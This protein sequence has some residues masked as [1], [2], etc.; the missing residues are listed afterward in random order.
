MRREAE[1]RAGGPLVI[2]YSSTISRPRSTACAPRAAASSGS[3]SPFRVADVS[4]SWTRRATNSRSGPRSEPSPCSSSRPVSWGW[5]S[6]PL[7]RW[8]VPVP[9]ELGDGGDDGG[10]TLRELIARIVHAE[11]EAFEA[12]A[13]CPA[14]GP[15]PHRSGDPG[16]RG[17]R[18][19]RPWGSRACRPGRRGVGRRR[20][21]P[22]VRGRALSGDPRRR[23][24]AGSGCA[25]LPDRGQSN[26][27]SASNLS[28]WSVSDA[29]RGGPGGTRREA[30]ARSAAGAGPGKYKARMLLQ[31]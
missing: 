18:Q 30:Q 31:K 6:R 21:A 22:G 3:R 13:A 10:L 29:A 20:R 7:D 25:G 24:T 8:S 28:G 27:L 11:V 4:T 23:G 2:L 14:P 17:A 19:G 26:R 16:W 1:V 5:K 9:P 12:R 15:L